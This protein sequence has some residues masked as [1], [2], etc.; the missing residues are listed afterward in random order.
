MPRGDA[1]F[2]APTRVLRDRAALLVS[3]G[4]GHVVPFLLTT[5]ALALP[6]LAEPALAVAALLMI[7]GQIRMK[8]E[9]IL[10]AGQLRPITIDRLRLPGVGRDPAGSQPGWAGKRVAADRGSETSRRRPA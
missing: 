4:G 1:A 6:D 5:L 10:T 7:D 2:V 9:L 3:V 8:A